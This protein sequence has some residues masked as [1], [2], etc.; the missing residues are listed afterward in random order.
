ME[1]E[2]RVRQAVK[3][4]WSTRNGK[5]PSKEGNLGKRTRERGLQ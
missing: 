2:A 1:L 5:Q 3:Y 4:F